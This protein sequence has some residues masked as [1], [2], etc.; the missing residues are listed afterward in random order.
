[1]AYEENVNELPTQ[2]PVVGEHKEKLDPSNDP[3]L[4]AEKIKFILTYF[5]KLSHSMLQVG[6]GMNVPSKLWR[7]ILE[8][9]IIEKEVKVENVS[10]I[11]PTGR[12]QSFTIYMLG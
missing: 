9:M 2:G 1:M 5:P 10:V 7:P 11:T 8:E 4:T 12:S 3:A 6:I